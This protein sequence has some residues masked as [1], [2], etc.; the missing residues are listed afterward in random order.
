MSVGDTFTAGTTFTGS[1]WD[2]LFSICPGDGAGVDALGEAWF[3]LILALGDPAGENRLPRDP[4]CD[5]EWTASDGETTNPRPCPACPTET[6]DSG[7]IVQSAADL[8]AGIVRAAGVDC[9]AAEVEKQEKEKCD[10]EITAEDDPLFCKPA[11]DTSDA[12]RHFMMGATL[13]AVVLTLWK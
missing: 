9:I 4:T 12:G 11:E 1:D 8:A 6:D 5:I 2:W 3:D 10:P 13:L 7:A